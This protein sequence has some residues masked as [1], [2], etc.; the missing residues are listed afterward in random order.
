MKNKNTTLWLLTGLLALSALVSCKKDDTVSEPT[1]EF[2]T[3]VDEL[4]VRF[5]S[6]SSNATAYAWDFGDNTPVST[7]ASPT[8]TY[9]SKGTY[10]VLLTV[11]GAAGSTP[12]KKNGSVSVI[13]KCKSPTNNLLKGGTM[14]T[15]DA[16]FWTVLATTGDERLEGKP[17]VGANY[18]FGETTGAPTACEGGSGALRFTDKTPSSGTEGSIFYQRVELTAGSYQWSADIKFAGTNKQNTADVNGAHQ[19]W[20][21]VYLDSAVPKEGDGYDNKA[22]I[23]GFNYWIVNGG[24]LPAGSDIPAVDGNFTLAAEPFDF[25]DKN[26]RI[27]DKNGKFTITNAGTY[28]F[29]FKIGKWQGRYG[30]G[31]ISVDNLTLVKL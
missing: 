20:F 24:L 8:H 28:T 9:A 10:Q 1:A 2:T 19:F 22:L 25:D 16:S 11:T 31:G 3:E 12:A 26:G 6:T 30:S 7:E 15:G 21:E 18:K 23:S 29:A 14:E 4:T 27:A 17:L 5:K 13:R